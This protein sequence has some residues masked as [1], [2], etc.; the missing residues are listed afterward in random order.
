MTSIQLIWQR[1]IPKVPLL[2]HYLSTVT[3]LLP[4]LAFTVKPYINFANFCT[5]IAAPSTIPPDSRVVKEFLLNKVG[6]TEEEIT[7]TFRRCGYLLYAKSG[8]NL[9]EVLELLNSCGLTTLAQMRKV[10]LCNPYFVFRGVEINI[11]SKLRL[12]RTLM[13]EEDISRL[14]YRNSK[15]FN[16]GEG[17]M[18]EAIALL[19]RLGVEGQALSQLL[20]KEPRLLSVSEEKVTE[21]FKHIEDLGFDKGSKMFAVVLR[22][23]LGVRKDSL[24]RR[25]HCLSSLGFSE[26][27][28]SQISRRKPMILGLSE[29]NLRRHVDFLVNSVGLPLDD[30]VKYAT[31]PSLSLEKRIIPRYRVMEALKSMQ[32]WKKEMISPRIFMSTEKCF[33]HKYVNKNA[34]SSIL[35]DIYHRGKVEKLI[36]NKETAQ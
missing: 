5:Q 29:E 36:I 23:I 12:L 13:K 8:Q 27:Q 33:L 19:Q 32:E 7:K 9:D 15:I 26:K 30:L 34:D 18:R 20:A 6:L 28:I 16:S 22:S 24:E 1:L 14:V 10:V 25:L 35:L 3:H 17:R 2:S 21:S 11:Q 4:S 31:L